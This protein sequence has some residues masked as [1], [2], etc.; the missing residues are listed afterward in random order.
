MLSESY[1]IQRELKLLVKL[2]VKEMY[3][4]YISLTAT[5]SH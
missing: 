2:R 3:V 1:I 5:I 4:L